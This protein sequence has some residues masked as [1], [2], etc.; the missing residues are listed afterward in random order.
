MVNQKDEKFFVCFLQRG[1]QIAGHAFSMLPKKLEFEREKASDD[2]SEKIKNQ[3]LRK[4]N[5]FST[6][7]D[8]FVAT[9]GV[10]SVIHAIYAKFSTACSCLG[11]WRVS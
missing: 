6:V 10:L 9:I 3:H 1:D 2:T 4:E 11:T 8:D 7:F 5:D